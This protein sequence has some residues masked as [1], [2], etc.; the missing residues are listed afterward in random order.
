MQ[1][2]KDRDY[3]LFLIFVFMDE[4]NKPKKFSPLHVFIV[5]FVV[6]VVVIAFIELSKH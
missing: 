1:I 3:N 4:F 2:G 6:G 5:A